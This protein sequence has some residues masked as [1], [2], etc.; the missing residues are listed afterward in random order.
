MTEKKVRC[1]VCGAPALEIQYDYEMETD[2]RSGR[3][4]NYN[5]I[6]LCHAHTILRLQRFLQAPPAI[7]VQIEKDTFKLWAK[8]QEW[9]P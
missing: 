8:G 7:S 5:T 3:E 6:D 1:D 9:K 2:A 4:I